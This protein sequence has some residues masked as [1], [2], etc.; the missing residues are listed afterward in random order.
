MLILLVGA[1]SQKFAMHINRQY[2][3]SSAVGPCRYIQTTT[4]MAEYLE[5]T[6]GSQKLNPQWEVIKSMDREGSDMLFYVD[7]EFISGYL[8]EV[9]VVN[10]AGDVILDTCV[11]HDKSWKQIYNEGSDTTR[12]WLDKQKRKFAWDE[13]LKFPPST[14]VMDATQIASV[15]HAASC[16]MPEAKFVEYSAGNMD[17]KLIQNF[18]RDNGGLEH[19]LS[20][21]RG[22]GALTL[23]QQRLPG[24]WECA[25][26]TIFAFCRPDDPLSKLSHRALVD[27]K[28]LRILMRDL[29]NDSAA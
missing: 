7:T 8:I 3:D 14:T 26:E 20:N 19:V 12:Y 29:F 6:K 15:L 11:L 4:G 2:L 18:L 22:Y 21:H 1:G 23:W 13:E 17:T 27:A 25:Q 5:R 10:A 28:K 16:S 24:F 9:G